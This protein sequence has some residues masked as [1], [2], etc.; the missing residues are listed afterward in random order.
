MD[1]SPTQSLLMKPRSNKATE[2]QTLQT[3][4]ELAF[5]MRAAEL[6]DLNSHETGAVDP[7]KSSVDTAHTESLH[8]KRCFRC[9][10]KTREF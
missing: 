9:I 8:E 4:H 5:G 3:L 10:E 7:Q 2:G 6:C 1:S